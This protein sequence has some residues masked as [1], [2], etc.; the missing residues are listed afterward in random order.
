MA[1]KPRKM[2]PHVILKATR[3]NAFPMWMYRMTLKRKRV[4]KGDREINEDLQ[5]C[6]GKKW[7]VPEGEWKYE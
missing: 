1:S 3:L 4:H 6:C 2:S 7:L 5:M